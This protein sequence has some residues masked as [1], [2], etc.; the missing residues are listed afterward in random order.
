MTISEQFA[1]YA[2]LCAIAQK[3]AIEL[4]NHPDMQKHLRMFSTKEVAEVLG[5][6][7][8]YIRQLVR[9]NPDFPQG[10]LGGGSH[11]RFTIEEIHT[12]RTW[13]FEKHGKME[14]QPRRREGE[15]IQV[16]TFVNFKGGSGK[17]TSAVHFAQ[18][19]AL[20]GYR[21]LLVDLDPQASATTLHGFAPA[22]EVEPEQ[23]FAAWIRQDDD[24]D[25]TTTM[26]RMTLRTYWPHLDLVPATVAL[27]Q[28]EFEIMG[29]LRHDPRYPFYA[30]GKDFVDAVEK[31][32]DVIVFDCRP[33]VGMLTI[34]ALVAA[35]ALVIP[36]PPSMVDFASS[37]EFF[38]FM[39]EVSEQMQG[40]DESYMNYDFVKILTTKFKSND[41]NQS[42]IVKWTQALFQG[43]VLEDAMLDTV[44]LD[45]AGIA[46][47]SLYEYEPKGNRDSYTRAITSLNAA[48]AAILSEVHIAW[49][50]A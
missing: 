36:M 24:D 30:Q 5:V 26:D 1:R 2:E 37:G 28:V 40:V 14:Y 33:D 10:T 25:L 35:T 11:R 42:E 45:A 50:R 31:D 3:Q 17:T 13:L 46:M 48:N 39:A 7:D 38:R 12:A 49:G 22:T 32:Y 19:L 18:Y 43:A 20:H 21:T 9:A 34:N 41:K 44:A 8:A 29:N 15:E 6:T 47:T 16:V 23:T 27:Q 4:E